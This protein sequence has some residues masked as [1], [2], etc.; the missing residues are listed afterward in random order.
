[1]RYSDIAATQALKQAGAVAEAD[2][3]LS[4]CIRLSK[5][6]AHNIAT[7]RPDTLAST[8]G[9]RGGHGTGHVESRGAAAHQA[10]RLPEL[11]RAHDPVTTRCRRAIAPCDRC[12]DTSLPRR[13]PV[14]RRR[15]S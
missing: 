2:R 15:S 10:L 9:R 1:M 6:D 5:R 12:F 13:T 7:A 8:G 11:A 14:H 4:E 3:L